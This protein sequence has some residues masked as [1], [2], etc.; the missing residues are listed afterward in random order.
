M[1]NEVCLRDTTSREIGFGM[2]GLIE[3]GGAAGGLTGAE[4]FGAKVVWCK[5]GL[6]LEG[7]A[8]E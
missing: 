5:S 1:S 6:I 7:G 2:R 4:V 8:T 3:I